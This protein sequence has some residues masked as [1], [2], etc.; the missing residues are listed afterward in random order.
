[1]KKAVVTFWILMILSL[2]I[3]HQVEAGAFRT[4]SATFYYDVATD[5]TAILTGVGSASGRLVIPETLGDYKVTA[6]GKKFA[7]EDKDITEVVIPKTVDWIGDYAFCTP[8]LQAVTFE[9]DGLELI[10]MG[11]FKDS[12]ITSFTFP[13]TVRQVGDIAFANTALTGIVLPKDVTFWGSGVFEHSRLASVSFEEGFTAIS[14]YMFYG[15]DSLSALTLPDSLTTIG[16]HAFGYCDGIDELVL[17]KALQ[18]VGYEAF[19]FIDLNKL[20]VECPDAALERR[21]FDGKVKELHCRRD[22]SVYEIFKEDIEYG[23]TKYVP[24]GPYLNT[25]SATIKEGAKKQLVVKNAKGTT[26]WSSSNKKVAKVS[27]KGVVTAVKKGTATITAVNGGVTMQCKI[28]VKALTLSKKATV[29][30]GKKIRLKISGAKKIKW[31][32]SNKK[33]ASVNTKGVV[34]GKKIGKATITAKCLG[35]KYKCTVKVAENSETFGTNSPSDYANG[36]VCIDF[37][38]VKAV[39]N[40]YEVAGY[41]VNNSSRRV[42]KIK[43]VQITLYQDEKVV[44]K[45]MFTNI[46]VSAPPR[47]LSKFTVTFNRKN[48][49]KKKVD[50][51]SGAVKCES[52]RGF[53]S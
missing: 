11:A 8:S 45:Q 4:E 3:T 38:K 49:K 43:Q 14:E 42:S 27:S 29:T 24:I 13:K 16:Q 34:T 44:A 40:T 30:L 37:S 19:A 48:V 6:V 25:K 10:G 2:G 17:P 20:V 7:Y 46:K 21:W 9:G 12:S 52:D 1:M 35:K 26:S 36:I 15:C 39:G 23:D 28:T 18:S 5:G 22:S 41:I 33:V 31:S 53:V 47:S 32:S 50:L 51:R